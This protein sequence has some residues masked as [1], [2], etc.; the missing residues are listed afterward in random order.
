M[1]VLITADTVGGVW[2]YTRELACGLLHRGHR[3]TLVSFGRIPSACPDFMDA[4]QSAHLPCHRL[5]R[6]SGCRRSTRNCRIRK[7]IFSRSFMRQQTGSAPLQPVLLRRSRMWHPESGRR[8]QRRRELVARCSWKR[9]S[10]LGLDGLV[11]DHSLARPALCG[12]RRRSVA[13]DARHRMCSTT[14]DQ[15]QR[16]RDLQRTQYELVPPFR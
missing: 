1:H 8:A 2:T 13:V 3:V 12:Y 14:P 6:S 15:L 16:L 5:S 9:S 7:S 4:A 10:I 11:Q